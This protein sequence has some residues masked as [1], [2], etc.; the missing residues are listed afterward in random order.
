MNKLK[1][2]LCCLICA[3]LMIPCMGAQ[4]FNFTPKRD[5][6]GDGKLEEMTLFSEAVYMEDMNTGE[7]V[8]GATFCH[9]YAKYHVI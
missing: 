1:R 5:E 7:P 4:A 6:D 8:N 9:I 2:T 3:V